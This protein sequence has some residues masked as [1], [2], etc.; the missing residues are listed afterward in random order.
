MH[1]PIYDITPFSSLDYPDKTAC[2]LWFAG[3]NMRCR[4]CYNPQIVQGKGRKSYTDAL[5]FLQQRKGLLDGVVLSGGECTLHRGLDKFAKTIKDLGM[6]IKV[7]TNGS[8]PLKLKRMLSAKLIDY[9]ALDFKAPPK[10]FKEVTNSNLFEQFDK[11]LD[12]LRDSGVFFEVRSTYHSALHSLDD[13]QS[14]LNLLERKNYTGDFFVQNF[15]SET[16]TL[17]NLPPSVPLKT[18]GA[19]H[20]SIKVLIRNP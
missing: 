17:G 15:V 5:E 1:R 18:T 4:Y 14:M 16:P 11:S 3:C 6:L 8:S 20:S 10:T 9:V 19:L 13:L 2:I 7:D 12:V